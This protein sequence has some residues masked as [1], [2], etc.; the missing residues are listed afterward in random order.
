MH[1]E[2]H[3]Q[4]ETNLACSKCGKPICPRCLVQTPVGARCR[5]CARL[6]GVPMYQVSPRYLLQATAAG[7]A[8][9]LPA[10]LVW[11]LFNGGILGFFAF[12]AAIG[13]GYGVGE[14]ISYS[15]NRKRGTVLQV[16]AVCSVVLSYLVGNVM[17]WLFKTPIPFSLAIRHAFDF[18]IWGVVFAAVAAFM[19]YTRLR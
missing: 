15:V 14:G 18:G 10:G 17:W 1:C 11:Y 13:V 5:E 12:F 2:V 3:P 7:I 8:L 9:A 6:K 16:V 4:V 19:A